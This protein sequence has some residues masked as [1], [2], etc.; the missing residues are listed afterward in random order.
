MGLK[1]LV[2]FL[3]SPR[4]QGPSIDD[5]IGLL[6]RH[7]LREVDRARGAL[8]QLE[9]SLALELDNGRLFR[10]LA[11]LGFVNERPEFGGDRRWS[12]TGDRYLLKLFR[13]YVFHQVIFFFC[14]C[15]STN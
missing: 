7:L 6:P 14:F 4:Q 11:K 5:V 13:D 9:A 1:S 15:L 2:L 10:L 8:D 3:I 12:E